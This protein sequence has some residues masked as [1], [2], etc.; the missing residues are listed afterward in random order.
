MDEQINKHAIRQEEDTFVIK[1]FLSA[2]RAEFAFEQLA[3]KYYEQMAK[4]AGL[5]IGTVK[6]KLSRARQALRE[7]LRRFI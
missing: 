5:N 7:R 3:T 1:S 4:I 6:S 2:E